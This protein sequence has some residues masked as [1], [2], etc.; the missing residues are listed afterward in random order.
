MTV[1]L[2]EPSYLGCNPRIRCILLPLVVCLQYLTQ[3]IRD[4]TELGLYSWFFKL[5]D[6]MVDRPVDL[7]VTPLRTIGWSR[8]YAWCKS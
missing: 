3:G 1:A 5:E 7:H 4:D 6:E 8:D 2:K